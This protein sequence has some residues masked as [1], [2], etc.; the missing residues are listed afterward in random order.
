MSGKS[1]KKARKEAE[2]S[3]PQP[4]SKAE[5]NQHYSQ[6]AQAIGDRNVKIKGLEFELDQLYRQVS[7]LGAEMNAREAVDAQAASD[8]A[9]AA[10]VAEE[11]P[12]PPVAGTVSAS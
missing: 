1:S 7:D 4:R 8:A 6:V 3:K 2:V 11:A 10:K 5:I 9:K 12:V